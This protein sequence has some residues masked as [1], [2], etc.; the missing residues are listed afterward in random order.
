MWRVKSTDS[1]LQ[2]NRA[3]QTIQWID[4]RRNCK[5]RDENLS[6]LLPCRA[7]TVFGRPCYFNTI[8]RSTSTSFR[9]ETLRSPSRTTESL[10]VN[11][12]WFFF[13]FWKTFFFPVGKIE[14]LTR[15]KVVLQRNT[16]ECSDSAS[17]PLTENQ[18]RRRGKKSF[19]LVFNRRSTTLGWTNIVTNCLI[20]NVL[21][22]AN[23]HGRP[24]D[25]QTVWFNAR[26]VSYA[27]TDRGGHEAHR[28]YLVPTRVRGAPRF[29]GFF[30]FFKQKRNEKSR[31]S[32]TRKRVHVHV[33]PSTTRK[34]Q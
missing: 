17:S 9:E 12:E 18:R 28:R 20:D 19:S 10:P 22:S 24:T 5:T 7:L 8:Q 32:S 23:I 11:D 33:S 3:V 14:K 2:I 27:T 31:P 1:I 30:F 6:K 25:L 34:N 15:L 26:H 4:F 16:L 13:L 29:D 21:I